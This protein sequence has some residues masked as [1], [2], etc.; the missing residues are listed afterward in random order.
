MLAVTTCAHS[1]GVPRVG[2]QAS[3]AMVEGAAP[4]RGLPSDGDKA[5]DYQSVQRHSY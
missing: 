4:G 2:L 5:T 3:R 1:S